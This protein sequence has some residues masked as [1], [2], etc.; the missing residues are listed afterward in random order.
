MAVR[1][2][3]KLF[4]V[5][6]CQNF[7]LWRKTLM[8]TGRKGNMAHVTIKDVYQKNGVIHVIDNGGNA[9]INIVMRFR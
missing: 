7:R 8:L 2:Q 1:I 5:A 3:L 9:Q 6:K 4:R